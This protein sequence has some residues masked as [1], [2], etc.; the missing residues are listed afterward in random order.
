MRGTGRQAADA[1]RGRL[2]WKY[3]LGLELEDPGFHFS[4]LGEFRARLVENKA[5]QMLLDKMLAHFREAGLLKARG[6]AR[7]D[8]T[9]VLASVRQ[10]HKLEMVGEA[11]RAALNGLATAAP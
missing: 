9:H 11:V 4:V 1:V 10:L 5:E 2:D 8:S 6:H 3:A 7:T